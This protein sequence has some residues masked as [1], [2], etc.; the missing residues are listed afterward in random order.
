MPWEL[1]VRVPRQVVWLG[2]IVFRVSGYTGRF[3]ALVI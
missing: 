2:A 1:P 3:R